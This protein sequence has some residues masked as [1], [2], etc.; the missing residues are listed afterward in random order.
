MTNT[1]PVDSHSLKAGYPLIPAPPPVI[2]PQAQKFRTILA[3][4]P[5]EVNQAGTR[6][7]DRHYQLMTIERIKEIG[8]AHV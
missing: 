1:L 6:G 2:P 3:D 8:R 7:A 5:W 4:P